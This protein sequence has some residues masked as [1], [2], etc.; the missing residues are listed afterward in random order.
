MKARHAHWAIGGLVLLLAGAIPVADD[1]AAH[2][3]MQQK[4]LGIFAD[5]SQPLAARLAAGRQLGAVVDPEMALVVRG[6][7]KDPGQA[8][9]V[10]K[11]ALDDLAAGKDPGLIDDLI[12]LVP[13]GATPDESLRLACLN[14]LR[15]LA[16]FSA[17][18]RE[19]DS[20]IVQAFRSALGDPSPAVRDAALKFLVLRGDP[21][22]TDYLT[23]SL[24]DRNSPL[25]KAQA[26]RY[27][28]AD[29][30]RKHYS[31]IRP[32]LQDENP[33]ARAE[34]ATVL[35]N[36]LQSRDKIKSLLADSKQPN[37][38]RIAAA[39]SLA[40]YD[41]NFPQYATKII[42]QGSE[43]ADV[44]AACL[45][46]LNVGLQYKRYGDNHAPAI[47]EAIKSVLSSPTDQG[48]TVRKAATSAAA[49]LKIDF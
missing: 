46:Q 9:E 10:R 6:L 44:R 31:A 20:D 37:N 15:V 26:I 23:A 7:L 35:G 39:G 8:A 3:A 33:A 14:R 11:L 29:D 38:V 40:I 13:A 4:A 48:D 5:K 30:P 32:A 49:Q 45:D 27:L 2:K 41:P 12:G 47:V 34:A 25:L 28:S 18:G 19:R 21:T 1:P 16:S 24:K 36:D 17:A 43:P 42:T 22:A